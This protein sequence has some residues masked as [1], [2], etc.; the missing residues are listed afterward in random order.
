MKTN[1]AAIHEMSR[2]DL[3]NEVSLYRSINYIY[4][5]ELLA[6]G[7]FWVVMHWSEIKAEINRIRNVTPS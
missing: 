2:E 3:I 4:L 7:L 6:K 5:I 1:T